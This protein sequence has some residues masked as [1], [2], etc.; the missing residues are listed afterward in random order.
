MIA[1]SVRHMTRGWR[2][3]RSIRT[4]D[5]MGTDVE[6]TTGLVKGP[7]GTVVVGLA[8]DDGPSAVLR[9]DDSGPHLL[10]NLRNSLADLLEHRGGV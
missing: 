7:D 1:L 3:E 6:V 10:A 4:T 8:I 5:T 9:I 2:K